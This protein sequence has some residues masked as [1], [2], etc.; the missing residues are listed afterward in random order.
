MKGWPC[1]SD[2]PLCIG[3]RLGVG[4][5]SIGCKEV[6]VLQALCVELQCHQVAG[7]REEKGC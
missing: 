1:L 4:D 2:M 3:R 6:V 5:L 7:G